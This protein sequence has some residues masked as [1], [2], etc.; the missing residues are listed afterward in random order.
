M[1]NQ[2]GK[3]RSSGDALEIRPIR[4]DDAEAVHR[5][6][7]LPSVVRQTMGMPSMRLGD[8]R[9]R[10]EGYGPDDHVFVAVVGGELVGMAGLHVGAGKQRHVGSV[11]IMVADEHQGRG[12][13]RA[14]MAALLDV[15]DRYLGLVRVELDVV[16]E[17]S[18][19][20]RMYET[21]G[22]ERE[23][24]KRAALLVDGRLAD[25]LVMGR[26]RQPT[27]PRQG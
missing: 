14:L 7:R 27:A 15:A 10:I 19:A 17:S 8:V 18:G 5:I 16:A 22:F 24:V 3:G 2:D 9:R 23:G 1:S 11:G 4:P 26:I 13:G 12:I 25:L 20:I 21:L 6:R